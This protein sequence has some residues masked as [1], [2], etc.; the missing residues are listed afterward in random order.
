[1]E[2]SNGESRQEYDIGLFY[3][4]Y[5]LDIELFLNPTI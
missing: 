2:W 4:I 3:Q 1:M 5:D